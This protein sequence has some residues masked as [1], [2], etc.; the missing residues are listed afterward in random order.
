M[1]SANETQ[2]GGSHYKSALQHWDFATYMYGTGYLRG[3]VTKYLCRWRKKNGI[4]DLEKAHHFLTKLREV[5][6]NGTRQMTIPE[7]IKANGIGDE[8]AAIIFLLSGTGLSLSSADN[9]LTQLIERER[10]AEPKGRGYVEQD[11]GVNH[12]S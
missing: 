6:S 1:T 8:E 4:Q 9:I 3:Q 10:A 12:V 5:L 2:V 11:G 7:F